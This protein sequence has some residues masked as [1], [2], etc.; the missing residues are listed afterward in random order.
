MCHFKSLMYT[1][2]SKDEWK[3]INSTKLVSKIP[4]ACVRFQCAMC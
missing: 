2:Y 4:E 3:N 1:L